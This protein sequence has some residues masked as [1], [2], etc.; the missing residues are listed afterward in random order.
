MG[1]LLHPSK[2]AQALPIEPATVSAGR[3]FEVAFAPGDG[4]PRV[5][6]EDD[7]A[8]ADGHFSKYAFAAVN[9]PSHK[10]CIAKVTVLDTKNGNVG[11]GADSDLPQFRVA[12]FGGWIRG[13]FPNDLPEGDAQREHLTHHIG[14]V[15]HDA[16]SGVDV[17]VG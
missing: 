9:L 3:V 1:G 14:Q 17:E 15:E 8:R 5:E 4:A 6:I 2:R 11:D 16:R 13:R 7:M 12:D 10:I